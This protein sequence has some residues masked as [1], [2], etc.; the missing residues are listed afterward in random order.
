MAYWYLVPYKI[1]RKNRCSESSS[2]QTSLHL[3]ALS[4]VFTCLECLAMGRARGVFSSLVEVPGMFRMFRI[5]QSFGRS[6]G[7]GAGQDAREARDELL[8]LRGIP[9]SQVGERWHAFAS[10]AGYY[11][12]VRSKLKSYRFHWWVPLA[13]VLQCFRESTVCCFV[14]LITMIFRGILPDIDNPKMET[15]LLHETSSFVRMGFYLQPKTTTSCRSPQP[16]GCYRWSNA[17]ARSS[18]GSASRTGVARPPII[19]KVLVDS[20]WNDHMNIWVFP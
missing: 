10:R 7:A 18:P 19:E 9:T 16:C 17:G 6:V 5:F 11:C 12:C 15:V 14:F 1:R 3:F 8:A 20:R 2:W 13:T 4:F